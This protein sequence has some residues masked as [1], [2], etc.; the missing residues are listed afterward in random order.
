MV[1]SVLQWGLIL[2]LLGY[3]EACCY[4]STRTSL[5]IHVFDVGQADSQLIVFPSGFSMLIDVGEPVRLRASKIQFLNYKASQF[6]SYV[7]NV[8]C[9][10]T[11]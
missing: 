9:W 7:R 5:E 11:G 10:S 1:Y 8:R 3:S 2:L 4:A 6:L